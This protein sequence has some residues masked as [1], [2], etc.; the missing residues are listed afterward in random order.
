MFFI[1]SSPRHP[2][3]TEISLR[4]LEWGPVIDRLRSP[5]LG[6]EMGANSVPRRSASRNSF[7]PDP[8]TPG[9]LTRTKH[10]HAQLQ[11]SPLLLFMTT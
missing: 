5:V 2:E 8:S 1:Y 3:L 4:S 7:T 6:M 10:S 9:E 11:N